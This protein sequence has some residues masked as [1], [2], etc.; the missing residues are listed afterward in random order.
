MATLN[1]IVNKVCGE[2]NTIKVREI[3]PTE[4]RYKI[5]IHFSITYPE[6]V[7]P[8][9]IDEIIKRLEKYRRIL[10]RDGIYL[11]DPT[12]DEIALD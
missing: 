4:L 6:R 9:K 3:T 11:I 7:D 8:L 5:A 1:Q 12:P 10:K 2:L